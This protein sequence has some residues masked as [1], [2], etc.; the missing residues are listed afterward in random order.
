MFL[1]LSPV[2]GRAR[3]LPVKMLRFFRARC[4][5]PSGEKWLH[6]KMETLARHIGESRLNVSRQ[7]RQWEREGLIQLSRN[8]IY[9]PD[10]ARFENY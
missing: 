1:N 4:L 2:R 7:L 9:I 5:Q 6:I 3:E 8:N 10:G